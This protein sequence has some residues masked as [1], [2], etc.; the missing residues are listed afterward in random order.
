MNQSESDAKS[1]FLS[2]RFGIAE[3]IIR[4]QSTFQNKT[5]RDLHFRKTYGLTALAIHR[6]GEYI[7]IGVGKEKLRPGDALLIHGEWKNIE[8]FAETIHEVVVVGNIANAATSAIASG[9]A[10]I[11]G[12]I[13]MFMLI[14]M[15]LEVFDP[16]IT[17]LIS[18]F[19]MLITGCLR[20]TEDAYRT[21][22]W[23]SVILIAAMLPMAIAL[24]KT[25]GIQFISDTLIE[26]LGSHGP[27]AVLAGFYILTGI[28]SQ[29][30]SN[31]ATAVIFVPIAMTT[32]SSMGYSPYPFVIAVAISASMAFSTPVASPTNALVMNAGGYKFKDFVKVGVPLQIFL[33]IITIMAIPLLYPF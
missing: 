21:I 7:H 20:S 2:K 22:N 25:G 3:M 16:V 6:N 11:A 31:T 18:A 29:F 17:V 30:I 12:S 24:E 26:T 9:K 5:I 33:A 13:M 8:A 10:R 15:T 19:L 27:L 32:A 4:P 23:E 1:Q 14:L 28:L